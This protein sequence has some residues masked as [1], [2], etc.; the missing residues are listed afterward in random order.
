MTVSPL[1]VFVD[2][3]F[4]FNFKKSFQRLEERGVGGKLQ[5]Q[6]PPDGLP[7]ANTEAQLFKTN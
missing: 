7:E 6:G 2:T 1:L 5:A 4:C 3:C